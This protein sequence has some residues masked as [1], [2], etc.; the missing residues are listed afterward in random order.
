MLDREAEG[1]NRSKKKRIKILMNGVLILC[2]VLSPQSSNWEFFY[3][4]IY[5]LC[6]S[7]RTRKAVDQ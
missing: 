2:R 6:I 1:T 4:K 3:K 5:I 7:Y